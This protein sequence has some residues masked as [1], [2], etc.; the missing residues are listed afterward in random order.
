MILV[1]GLLGTATLSALDYD[2]GGSIDNASTPTVTPVPAGYLVGMD[3]RNKAAVWLDMRFSPD[4]S[5]AAE[6]SYSF[7]L[8]VPYIF[9]IDY[10]KVDWQAL[11]SLKITAGRFVFSDFTGHVLNHKLDGAML[12][13]SVPTGVVTASA[14]YSGILLKPSSLIF[15]TR[16]DSVDQSNNAIYFAAPRLIEKIDA[17]VPNFLPRQDFAISL[18]LQQDLRAASTLIQPG[19][20]DLLVSGASGGSLTSEYL[21][22][23]LSGAIISNLYYNSFFFLNMGGTLGYVVDPATGMSSWEYAGIEAF[24]GGIGLR[25]FNEDLLS[26]R[27]ELQAVFSSG[28]ADNHTYQEGNTAGASTI[29]VPI[30]QDTLGIAFQPQWGNLVMIDANYSL[31]P[32]SRSSTVWR[33]LQLMLK[34]LNFLRPTTGAIS[35]IGLNSDSTD[36]FLGTEFDLIANF[37]P[38]SDL[39]TALSFGV[40]MPNDG[41][42]SGTAASPVF[43][44]RLEFSFSF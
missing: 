6:G 38:L 9:D 41:A 1:L 43:A 13:Y 2:F 37:R 5:L 17:L 20:Q 4:F 18:I 3:Q 23:G 7:S 19:E 35:P 8:L 10:L 26:S 16:S 21:G 39:G 42:F 28:D 32:F 36:L 29:F 14:G 12:T 11:P 30:S 34:V 22:L 40:F 33:N 31:K 24:L 27:A 25:Y 15:M 44:G